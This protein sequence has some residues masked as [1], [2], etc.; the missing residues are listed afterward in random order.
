MTN[1]EPIGHPVV[2]VRP[3][4]WSDRAFSGMLNR[5]GERYFLSD[6]RFQEYVWLRPYWSPCKNIDLRDGDQIVFT[7]AIFDTQF[8]TFADGLLVRETP[9]SDRTSQSPNS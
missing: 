5:E 4:I 7:K 3:P 8:Y 6:A 2:V 9:Y 1:P